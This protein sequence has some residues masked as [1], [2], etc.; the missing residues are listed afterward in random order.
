MSTRIAEPHPLAI[1]ANLVNSPFTGYKHYDIG[2]IHPFAPDWNTQPSHQAAQLWRPSDFS[3]F[4]NEKIQDATLHSGAEGK[5]TEQDI[6]R[7]LF[8]KP[9]YQGHPW[10]LLEDI[11]HSL[12]KTPMGI[13]RLRLPF[14]T[15][16]SAYGAAVSYANCFSF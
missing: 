5:I 6:N 3:L 8:T 11:D 1:S 7:Y 14:D 4:S 10:L 15:V 12:L 13:N 2:A 9:P 16:A